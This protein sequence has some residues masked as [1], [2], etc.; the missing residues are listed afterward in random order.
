LF[1]AA[2]ASGLLSVEITELMIGDVFG[3]RIGHAALVQISAREKL[4][5][6]NYQPAQMLP[7]N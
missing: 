5:I 4:I 1:A 3:A 6:L 2:I 7:L